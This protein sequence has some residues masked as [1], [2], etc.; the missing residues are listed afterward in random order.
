MKKILKKLRFLIVLAIA[1]AFVWF[2]VVSPMLTFH[3]NEKKLEDA[4]RRYFELNSSA[5]PTGERIK[6]LTLQE[7]YHN[8]FIEG[9]LNIPYS[10]KTCNVTNSWVKVRRENGEYKYYVYL[11]C[12]VLSSN[13]DHTG[14][15]I[16]LNGDEKITVGI[17]DSFSDPGVKSVVDDSDGKLSVDD[18]T[19]KGSVDTSHVGVYEI[20]YIALDNLS[21]KTTV[22]RTVEVVQKFSSTV[23]TLLDEGN[24]N[25]MGNPDNNY[26]LFSSMLF[27]IYGFDNNNN[28]IVVADQ[29]ISNVNY[30]SLDKWLDYYYDHLS[31]SSK[32]MIVDS[33]Y[34]NMELSEAS[35]DTTE[36]SSYTKKRSVY[37][38][39]VVEV[40]RAE[41]GGENFMKPTTMSWVANTQSSKKAYLTRSFFFG[42]E[43]GKSFLAYSVD[44]NYGVRPMLTISGD[45]LVSGGVGTEDDPLT[46][47]DIPAAKKGKTKVN[48]RYTGEYIKIGTYL[49]RI[50]E[51]M[52]DGTTKVVSD[53]NISSGDINFTFNSETSRLYNPKD[54]KSLGYYINNRISEYFDTSYFVNHTIE[55][56]IY[57]DKL[58]YGKENSTKEYKTVLSAPNM[59]EMF[60]ARTNDAFAYAYWYIN[61]SE[62]NDVVPAIYDRG[63]PINEPLD[64]SYTAGVRVVAYL[65]DELLINSGKGT[66]KSPY[67]IG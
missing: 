21:N 19:I 34:C 66:K 54:K 6:T 27:R 41:K 31:D 52:D 9:D 60:S 5:L 55:V 11:E 51:I 44:E 48:E 18:V 50:V 13:I 10:S 24:T 32:K 23:R 8:A 17:N 45:E 43:S 61:S 53:L 29:D 2:L 58:M 3:N 35:L 39:S 30:S 57:K 15:T 25:F 67:V 12:G 36:C 56:P 26:V 28:V 40:N 16:K 33:K 4:A 59:Y 63:V 49:F 37:I 14:P 22:T 64:G 7:L 62:N 1:G 20:K 38:P 42:E 47:G 65:K 46:F